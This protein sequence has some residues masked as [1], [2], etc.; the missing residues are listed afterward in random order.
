MW[1]LI[2]KEN[3]RADTKPEKMFNKNRKWKGFQ[4]GEF[5][6]KQNISFLLY[7]Y[8]LIQYKIEIRF[9][10]SFVLPKIINLIYYPSSM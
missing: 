1:Y 4:A 5:S 2:N 3:K 9:S 7:V 6:P 8:I 10:L